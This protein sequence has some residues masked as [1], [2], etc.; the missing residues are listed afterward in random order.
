MNTFALADECR[1][2]RY[3]TSDVKI[4]TIGLGSDRRLYHPERERAH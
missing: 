4:E 1:Q 3:K 2:T